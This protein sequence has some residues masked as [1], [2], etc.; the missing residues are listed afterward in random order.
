MFHYRSIICRV[1]LWLPDSSACSI[2]I[3]FKFWSC[4]LSDQVT[5]MPIKIRIPDYSGDLYT[6]NIWRPNFQMVWNSNGLFMC[7]ILYTRPTIW[8][9]DQHILK[10]DGVHLSGIQMV[11]LSGI[12]MAFENQTIW[13]PASFPPYELTSLQMIKK[14]QYP[15]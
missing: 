14:S 13:H 6:G 10:Q 8:M 1:K 3:P 12:Q 2:Q 5:E 7:Y 11:G 15:I 9:P 4:I